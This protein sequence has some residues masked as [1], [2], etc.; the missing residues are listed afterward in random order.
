MQKALVLLLIVASMILSFS[1]VDA[2]NSHVTVQKMSLMPLS[3]TQNDGQWDEQALFRAHAGGATFWFTKEK[4]YYQFT[5]R[6][7][8]TNPSPL[9]PLP[10]GEGRWRVERIMPC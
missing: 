2:A 10:R 5:R 8:R 1:F 6:T 3:F 9:T 4:V 7:P